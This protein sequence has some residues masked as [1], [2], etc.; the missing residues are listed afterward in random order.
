MILSFFLTVYRLG[1]TMHVYTGLQDIQPNDVD[2]HYPE[3]QCFDHLTFDWN[4]FGHPNN[5]WFQP[6]FD[7]H[8]YMIPDEIRLAIYCDFFPPCFPENA[9]PGL[10]QIP[11]DQYM[12]LDKDG[13]LWVSIF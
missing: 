7:F 8:I 3:T 10:F 4:P 11:E 9:D 13:N 6:H 5:G 1:L 2:C 12:P